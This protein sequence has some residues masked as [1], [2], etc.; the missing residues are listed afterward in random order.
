MPRV[1][2]RLQT[3]V[4]FALLCVGILPHTGAQTHAEHLDLIPAP[5]EVAPGAVRALPQGIR[6]TCTSCFS[7]PEDNFTAQDLNESLAARSIP[8]GGTAIT[9]QLTRTQG[10]PAEMQA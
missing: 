3:L 5:R 7:D 1:R 8:Q 9:V 10:I 4:P 6:I 2:I